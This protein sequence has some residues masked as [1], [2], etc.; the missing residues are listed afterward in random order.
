MRLL[1]KKRKKANKSF[2]ST[3]SRKVRR[4]RGYRHVNLYN[5]FQSTHSRRVRPTGI[6]SMLGELNISIHA[7]T[8][9]AT[10]LLWTS[11]ACPKTFQSTHSRR[12]RH[13]HQTFQSLY[14]FISI[15]ALTKSAT[16]MWPYFS[17]FLFISIHALT[18]SA[19]TKIGKW[20]QN[21]GKFQSTHSRRVRRAFTQRFISSVGNFNPRTHEECDGRL[22]KDSSLPWEISIHALTKSA[23]AIF[24]VL[25]NSILDIGL[26]FNLS[27]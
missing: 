14:W 19:T 11:S 7:L 17:S 16:A 1:S 12:V 21:V 26:K 23:T 6:S 20:G 8:K 25:F 13:S 27:R 3:H 22:L 4:L 24:R 9:S 5:Q 18:K 15:H 10:R 2:Q